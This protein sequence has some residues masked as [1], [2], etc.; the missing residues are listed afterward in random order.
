MR[1]LGHRLRSTAPALAWALVWALGSSVAAMAQMAQDEIATRVLGAR[2]EVFQVRTGT[3][4]GLFDED[5]VLASNPVLALEVLGASEID[6][7]VVP[8]T[9]DADEE[10]S[11]TAFF[12]PV[13]ETLYLAW[14]TRFNLLHTRITLRWLKAGAWSDPIELAGSAFSEKSGPRIA[15]TRESFELTDRFGAISQHTRSIVHTLWTETTG[16]GERVVYTPL[17]FIDGEPLAVGFDDVVELTLDP[18]RL[19]DPAGAGSDEERP[20]PPTLGPS[21]S[22]QRLLATLSNDELLSVL[23]IEPVPVD[24]IRLG[25]GV[26]ASIVPIGR[27]LCSAGD[28]LVRLAAVAREEVLT[29]GAERFHDSVLN[30]VASAVAARI[31]RAPAAQLCGGAI[32]ELAAVVYEDVLSAGTDALDGGR[33]MRIGGDVRASIVPIGRSTQVAGDLDHRIRIGRVSRHSLPPFLEGRPHV[34]PSRDGHRLIVAWDHE[35]RVSFREAA[36]GGGWSA[37]SNLRIDTHL[38]LP[39]A[40]EL[41]ERRLS[42]R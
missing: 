4:G 1:P 29:Q 37:L 18:E 33:R 13:T 7:H 30:H 9:E 22:P 19:V 24:L 12:E 31:V 34:M 21:D 14:S 8:G 2:G 39:S 36:S 23:S 42:G 28:G 3:V 17:V 6:R 27:L 11:A 41:L 40:L 5:S 32:Q 35:D 10:L 16:L 15:F 26:R 25:D 20:L 38:D